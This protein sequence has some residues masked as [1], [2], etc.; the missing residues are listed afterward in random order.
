MRNRLTRFCLTTA[1]AV[2]LGAISFLGHGG[3]HVVGGHTHAH[4]A[5]HDHGGHGHADPHG[6]HSH[7]GHTHDTPPA[8]PPHPP[9]HEDDCAICA[10]LLT[11]ADLAKPVLLEDCTDVLRA[12]A[13]PDSPLRPGKV[14][15]QHLIR[16]PPAGLFCGASLPGTGI[17]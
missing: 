15:S 5:G 9:F 16:G 11:P 17:G 6:C 10:Y 4:G 1:F 7:G 13:A 12:A 14:E 2:W 8:D 3:L